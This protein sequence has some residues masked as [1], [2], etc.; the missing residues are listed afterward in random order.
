MAAADRAG[1]ERQ[2]RYCVGPPFALDRRRELVPARLLY[3]STKPGLGGNGPLLL[4]SLQLLDGLAALV[5][6][7]RIHRRCY[8]A[9]WLERPLTRNL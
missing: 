7:Q 1:R 3:E 2:S 4:T 9:C 5:P 8:F 6:P